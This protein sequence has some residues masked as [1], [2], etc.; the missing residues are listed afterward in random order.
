MP[1]FLLLILG[2][3]INIKSPTFFT[4]FNALGTISVA[5]ILVFV[6]YKASR[7]GFHVN[8]T[9]QSNYSYISRMYIICMQFVAKSNVMTAKYTCF[10]DV[11]LCFVC[12][13]AFLFSFV[14][15]V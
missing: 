9:D 10:A 7:W 12:S 2:P 15:R 4:K 14:H 6:T 11:M 3:L 5:Y 13:V 1:F 8:F